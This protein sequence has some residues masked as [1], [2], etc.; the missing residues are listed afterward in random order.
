MFAKLKK[1]LNDYSKETD[2]QPQQEYD[3]STLDLWK[4]NAELALNV[5]AELNVQLPS[6]RIKNMP[7]AESD[8]EVYSNKKEF[9]AYCDMI[10]FMDN[11]MRLI[12]KYEQ[13]FRDRPSDIIANC[14]YSLDVLK[15]ILSENYSPPDKTEDTS[16]HLST[17][18]L[19]YAHLMPTTPGL[20]HVIPLRAGYALAL[21][22]GSALI[23]AYKADDK[24][25]EADRF[26]N[27]RKADDK[28]MAD[29]LEFISYVY[30]G[31]NIDK[32][33]TTDGKIKYY[34]M[35]GEI[36]RRLKLLFKDKT[37]EQIKKDEE[38]KK[39]LGEIDKRYK[40]GT[41]TPNQG[42]I[43]KY[44]KKINLEKSQKVTF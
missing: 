6:R 40:N 32:Y 15:S 36:Q 12:D 4:K 43:V 23:K 29:M 44:L 41:K 16:H 37:K 39:R 11:Y 28:K 19:L 5:L 21:L 2:K 24:G 1:Y 34:T 8:P 7:N 27:Q 14:G 31:L 33:R 20:S 30:D 25:F 9:L 26:T 18:Y 42:T 22:V 38:I 3:K 13:S 35:A 10:K 17:L